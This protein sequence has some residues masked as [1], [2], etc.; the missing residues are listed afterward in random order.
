VLN[1]ATIQQALLQAESWNAEQVLR[2]AFA[3][4][5]E[6]V[7]IASAFGPEG[8]V[9][10]DI[11]AKLC[12]RPKV[13]IIDTGFL[14]PETQQLITTLESRYRIAVERVLPVLSTRNQ[15]ERYGAALWERDPDL[16]CQIRKIAPLAKK[17]S[18][19][20][21]WITAIRRTQTAARAGARKVQWDTK[22]SC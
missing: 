22:F 8:I 19:L 7:E 3:T 10:L 15:E 2:W 20:S 11:T 14:F 16:C 1:P 17:L 13:F 6:Q 12:P 4:F 18:G 5:A 9:V 21:A